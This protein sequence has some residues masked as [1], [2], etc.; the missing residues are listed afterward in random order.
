MIKQSPAKIF[1]S[2]QRRLQQSDVHR[3]FSTFSFGAHEN[4][5]RFKFSTLYVLNDEELAGSGTIKAEVNAATYMVLL[6]IT[7]DL[8]FTNPAHEQVRVNVGELKIVSLPKRSSILL[9]NPFD[10]DTINYLQI[11]I[12]A[13]KNLDLSGLYNFDLDANDNQLIQLCSPVTTFSINIGRFTGRTE[14]I[15][16]LRNK[17]SSIFAFIIAGA[18]EVEHRLLHA[19]DGLALTAIEQI[20][21]EAL[22]D[23]AILLV[24]EL[25][26]TK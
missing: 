11:C 17:H 6:P 2:D 20:D 9:S 24:I 8:N 14:G 3:S 21:F 13:Y 7:G 25:F 16:K 4:T 22:S 15:Y 12:K 10:T 23:H 5:H 26:D 1:L 18:F 19:R